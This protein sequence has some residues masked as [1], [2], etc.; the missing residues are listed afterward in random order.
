MVDHG[1]SNTL[2]LTTAFLP[3]T[4]VRYQAPPEAIGPSIDLT[5]D[6]RAG[7][8]IY[9][10]AW[11]IPTSGPW[12]TPASLISNSTASLSLQG[13]FQTVIVNSDATLY[14][15][16]ATTNDSTLGCRARPSTSSELATRSSAPGFDFPGLQRRQRR[17][18]IDHRE[19]DDDE[20]GKRLRSRDNDECPGQQLPEHLEHGT[21]GQQ[22]VLCEVQL[23]AWRW[24]RQ[25]AQTSDATSTRGE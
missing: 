25:P 12:S 23:H 6:S 24:P 17:S 16:P 9:D 21:A 8:V 5:Q 3:T 14:A 20:R 15:A 11:T 18:P 19:P 13:A 4:L 22:Y 2:D 7:P 10:G 1:G